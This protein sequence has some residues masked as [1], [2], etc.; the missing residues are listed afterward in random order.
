[1]REKKN[2]KFLYHEKAHKQL[3]EFNKI[4][5]QIEWKNVYD[6]DMNEEFLVKSNSLFL[7]S[8][9]EFVWVERGK[10]KL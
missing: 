2:K 7:I 1:M 6:K 9:E 8:D 4:L 10:L 5:R 3:V